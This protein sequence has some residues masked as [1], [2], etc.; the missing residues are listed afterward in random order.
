MK[1]Y[2]ILF[3]RELV[4]LNF[5]DII[6]FSVFINL[7]LSDYFIREIQLLIAIF[8]IRKILIKHIYTDK[9]KTLLF[10]S[11]F[12]IKKVIL[13]NLIFNNLTFIS[14]SVIMFFFK[15]LNTFIFIENLIILNL[16]IC[17]SFFI[18]YILPLNNIKDSFLKNFVESIIYFT[19]FSISFFGNTTSLFTIFSFYI[20]VFIFYNRTLNY[21]DI[22]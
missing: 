10:I 7:N 14:I 3:L 21:Y 13:L 9:I 11:G 22:N 5:I 1:G 19:F 15:L 4:N 20:F 18:K 12:K 2:L 8:I 17:V 16:L 6:V